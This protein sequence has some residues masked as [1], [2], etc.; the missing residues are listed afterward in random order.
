MQEEQKRTEMG[1]GGTGGLREE[2]LR[3]TQKSVKCCS[4]DCP[5]PVTAS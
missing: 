3:K 2:S 4:P 5:W 1:G